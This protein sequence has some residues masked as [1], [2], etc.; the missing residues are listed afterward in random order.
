MRGRVCMMTAV[1]AAGVRTCAWID[2]RRPSHACIR[3]VVCVCVSLRVC[4]AGFALKVVSFFPLSTPNTYS[5]TTTHPHMFHS[6][7]F[8]FT[9]FSSGRRPQ[10][11]SVV[12]YGLNLE[13]VTCG[14]SVAGGC[15]E[16]VVISC[17]QMMMGEAVV[18]L[19]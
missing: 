15:T 17:R 9:H 19:Y 14:A 11:H 3:C 12:C 7:H 8:H 18:A 1:S 6:T 13:S 16:V 4:Y 2:W 5:H 10:L